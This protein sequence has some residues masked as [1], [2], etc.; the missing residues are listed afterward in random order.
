MTT[1]RVHGGPINNLPGRTIKQT[2]SCKL[3]TFLVTFVMGEAT[4]F[5]SA[6]LPPLLVDHVNT[7]Q[8]FSALPFTVCATLTLRSQVL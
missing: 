6:Y 2:I 5:I 8:E 4:S 1:V 3:D 7:N